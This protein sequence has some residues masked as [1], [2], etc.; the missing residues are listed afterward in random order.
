MW[1][2][3]HRFA[4]FVK[5][6]WPANNND[7]IAKTESFTKELKIWNREIFGKIQKNKKIL[8]ARLNGTQKALELGPNPYLSN[9]NV[10]LQDD[11]Q[12][13]VQQEEMYWLQKSLEKWH[14]QGDRN[15]SFFHLSTIVKRRRKKI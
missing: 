11:F 14:V 12:N 1:L 9:L 4:D 3:D 6:K 8:I 5:E 15:T 10:Q 7:I 13:S 2:S